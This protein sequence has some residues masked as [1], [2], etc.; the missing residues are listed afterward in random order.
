[1]CHP[2]SF[3]FCAPGSFIFSCTWY[4][5]LDLPARLPE[6]KSS[7]SLKKTDS[8]LL[9]LIPVAMVIDEQGKVGNIVLHQS[10]SGIGVLK[11]PTVL[12]SVIQNSQ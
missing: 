4:L 9:L 1:M 3:Y 10:R 12:N 6:G 7:L 11:A 8:S 5:E 2:N